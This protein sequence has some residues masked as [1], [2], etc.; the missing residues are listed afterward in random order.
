MV[1]IPKNGIESQILQYFVVKLNNVKLQKNLQYAIT[2]NRTERKCRHAVILIWSM[3]DPEE[4]LQ[5]KRKMQFTKTQIHLCYNVL[6]NFDLK[7]FFS[8]VLRHA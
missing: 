6:V 7:V 4:T 8:F 3:L 1:S 5:G 2:R